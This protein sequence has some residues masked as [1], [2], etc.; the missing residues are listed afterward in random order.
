[1]RKFLVFLFLITCVKYCFA[2]TIGYTGTSG[3]FVNL[4]SSKSEVSNIYMTETGT[5]SKLT[6]YVKSSTSST[7]K[8][9]IY[10]ITVDTPTII[11]SV[12]Q[13][14]ATTATAAW[15]DLTFSPAVVLNANTTYF[16]GVISGLDTLVFY[17]KA[18][19]GFN[20]YRAVTGNDYTSP[21]SPYPTS[22]IDPDYVGCIYGTYTAGGGQA[23]GSH[24]GSTII[25]SNSE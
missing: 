9:L 8:G 23:G 7:L 6:A 10:T 1:M 22:S 11:H 12:T 25:F 14:A 18:L 3:D 21:V 4:T 24:H 16:I 17:M 5:V 19:A 20:G 15:V 13:S 2:S